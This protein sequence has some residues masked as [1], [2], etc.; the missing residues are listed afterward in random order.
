MNYGVKTFVVGLPGVDVTFANTVAAAGGTTSA[1]LVA[2]GD[3]TLNFEN[4][5]TQVRGE[6]LP[7]T[8]AIPDMVANGTV[9]TNHVNVLYTPTGGPEG[10]LP[11]NPDCSGGVG[12]YYDNPAAPTEI[13]LFASSSLRLYP[14]GLRRRGANPPRLRH[15]HPLTRGSCDTLRRR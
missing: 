5:L 10:T 7:C 3:V 9:D 4:A 8:F 11:Q 12:W 1:I 15:R 13:V 6:T 2:T 14:R